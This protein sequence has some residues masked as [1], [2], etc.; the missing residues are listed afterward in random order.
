NSRTAAWLRDRCLGIDDSEVTQRVANRSISRDETFATDLH[1]DREIERELWRLIV[2]AAGD[3]REAG[4]EARTVTVRLRDADFTTRQAGRTVRLPITSERAIGALA[5]PLLR[6][7]RRARR[8]GARLVGVVLSGFG[9]PGSAIQLP[10]FDDDLS[11]MRGAAAPSDQVDDERDRTISATLDRVRS[12]FGRES[13]V[14]G[15]SVRDDG[16]PS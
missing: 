7:L 1:E 12:R 6:R 5:M 14:P 15:S 8:V 10:L 3:L 13:I 9:A 4:L 16:V 2:R 11:G